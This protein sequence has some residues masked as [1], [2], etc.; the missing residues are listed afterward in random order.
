MARARANSDGILDELWLQRRGTDPDRDPAAPRP[1]RTGAASSTRFGPVPARS[2]RR[3]GRNEGPSLEA[4][5][6]PMV[7][8]PFDALSREALESCT[9]DFDGV[10]LVAG[11]GTRSFSAGG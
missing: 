11:A 8:R 3:V 1:S 5:A 7:Q 4:G 6:L 2:S 9:V 10:L